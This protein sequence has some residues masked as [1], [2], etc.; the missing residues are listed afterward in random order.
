M[1]LLDMPAASPMTMSASTM[2]V[3]MSSAMSI[4]VLIYLLFIFPPG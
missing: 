1:M 3:M 4:A 2:I